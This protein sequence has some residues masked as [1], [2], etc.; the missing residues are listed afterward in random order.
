MAPVSDPQSRVLAER[1]AARA[2][3]H[4]KD[5]WRHQFHERLLPRLL[6]QNE[7]ARLLADAA[8]IIDTW[9]RKGVCSSD[10]IDRWRDILSNLP[11]KY[12]QELFHDASDWRIALESNSPFSHMFKG[13]GAPWL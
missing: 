4:A 2:E 13:E 8:E 5:A 3:K 12:E 10:Y 9:E 11:M 1:R 7:G 6:D